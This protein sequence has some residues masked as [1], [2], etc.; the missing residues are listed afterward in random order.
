MKGAGTLAHQR[1]DVGELMG[2]RALPLLLSALVLAGCSDDPA[3]GR[4]GTAGTGPT[5]AGRSGSGAAGSDDFGN[6]PRAGSGGTDGA[7]RA[8]SGAAGAS[9]RSPARP[10]GRVPS[11]SPSTWPS[12]ST[13]RAAW[14]RA[15]RTGTTSRSSGT[16][17][18][19]RPA[20]SSRTRLRRPD[21]IAHLLPRGGRRR[22]ALRAG[23]LC[24]ARRRDDRAPSRPSARRSTRSNRR[25]RTTGAAAR[26]PSS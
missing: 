3:G 17:S 13:S 8:G 6:A 25:T 7:G 21:R 14:A 24:R 15:T 23:V 16:R 10:S 1:E 9:G 22:R 4:N 5:T 26:R 19:L 12:H 18:W 2:S 20:R 11:S